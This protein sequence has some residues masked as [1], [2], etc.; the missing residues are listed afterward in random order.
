MLNLFQAPLLTRRRIALAFLVAVVA[1]GAQVALMSGLLL[2][3]IAGDV[4]DVLTM[5]VTTLLIGFHPL[6][7]PTFILELI[8]VVGMLPTWTGCV[9]A[10]VLLRKRQQQNPPPMPP[11]P[12]AP[13]D[14]SNV[15]DV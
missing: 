15:I 12:P 10:V 7:L 2:G 1:D 13:G 9:G 6:L 5:V 3:E 14:S 4:I 8:P 11:R